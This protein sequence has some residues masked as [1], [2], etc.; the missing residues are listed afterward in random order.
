MWVPFKVMRF[1][2]KKKKS[3]MI[4]NSFKTFQKNI[5]S[6]RKAIQKIHILWTVVLCLA[7]C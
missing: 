1:S 5:Y 4:K 6:F 7:M 2:L 3:D